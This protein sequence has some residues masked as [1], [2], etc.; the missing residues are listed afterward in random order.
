VD[1]RFCLPLEMVAEL[2]HV[3]ATTMVRSFGSD[4]GKA[5]SRHPLPFFLGRLHRSILY[6]MNRQPLGLRGRSSDVCG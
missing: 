1:E 6:S 3:T 4:I 5:I 2:E